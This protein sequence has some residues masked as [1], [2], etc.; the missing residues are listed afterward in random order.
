MQRG[1]ARLAMYAEIAMGEIWLTQ[2]DYVYFI[3]GISFIIF[4]GVCVSMQRF[5]GN[6]TAWGALAL[7]GLLHGLCEWLDLIAIAVA[8]SNEYQI[9]RVIAK[10]IS[11]LM[12][13]SFCLRCNKGGACNTVVVVIILAVTFIGSKLLYSTPAEADDIVRWLVAFPGSLWV[14]YILYQRA[15]VDDKGLWLKFVAGSFVAYGILGGLVVPGSPI[16]PSWAPTHQLFASV[17]GIPVQVLRACVAMFS[18]VAI[19]R[20]EIEQASSGFN[21]T[22]IRYFWRTLAL[23]F[24]VEMGG[25][26]LVNIVQYV[27]AKPESHRVIIIFCALVVSMQVIINY[28]VSKIK[29]NADLDR[30]RAEMSNRSKSMFLSMMSHELRT[31]LNSIIGFSEIIRDQTYGPSGVPEYIEY[32]GYINSAGHQLLTLVND[33]L[34]LSKIEAGKMEIDRKSIKVFDLLSEASRIIR[35]KAGKKGVEFKV[36][37]EFEGIEVYADERALRQILFNLLSNAIKFTPGGGSV[38]LYV[39]SGPSGRVLIEARDTGIGIH[40]NNIDRILKPFEQI[41]NAFSN[42]NGGTGLGLAVVQQLV[43]LHDAQF[44]VTSAPG[45]GSVFTVIFPPPPTVLE[46][47]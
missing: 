45:K 34:D 8:D 9:F 30:I 26:V 31:P 47:Q 27:G 41:D 36:E 33:I 14:S 16:A 7:F 11:F 18:A 4:G 19:W 29:L 6:G 38:T 5:E 2:L 1:G 13:F 44:H 43:K 17:T 39:G 24:I 32:A 15:C 12:L 20:Y 22:K 37:Q 40:P 23:L 25:F 35:V 21:D 28:I 10:L 46:R 3:Y 42:S